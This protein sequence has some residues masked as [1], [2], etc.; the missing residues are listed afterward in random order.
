[1]SATGH[2]PGWLSWKRE[3]MGFKGTGIYP[4]RIN[5][6]PAHSL[7]VGTLQAGNNE[8]SAR[9]K[10]T[11]DDQQGKLEALSTN[12]K[13]LPMIYLKLSAFMLLRYTTASS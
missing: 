7:T 3:Y 5:L 13:H 8:V 2:I 4:F 9:S 12:L 6:F 11:T 1:M 10:S